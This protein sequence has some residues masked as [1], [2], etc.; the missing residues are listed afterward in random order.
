M[1]QKCS[2]DF[3]ERMCYICGPLPFVKAVK[4]ALAALGIPNERISADVWG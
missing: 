4:D 3:S 1:I 2:P